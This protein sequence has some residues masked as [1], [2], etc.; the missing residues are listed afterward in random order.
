M[1]SHLPGSHAPKRVLPSLFGR[2][3]AVWLDH[4]ELAALL[5]RIEEMC[6]LLDAGTTDLPPA[7][8]PGRLAE[9]LAARL[10]RHFEAE[11]ASGYFSTMVRDEPALL[12]AIV[13][14]KADHVAMLDEIQALGRMASDIGQ[15]GELSRRARRLVEFLREHEAAESDLMRRFLNGYGTP[16]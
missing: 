13:G 1:T 7:L 2:L 8:R 10:V 12:P 16:D 14:L 15:W 11:E 6:R 9:N 4:G 3:T 5:P